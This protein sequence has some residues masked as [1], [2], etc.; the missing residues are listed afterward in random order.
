MIRSLMVGFCLSLMLAFGARA[1][2]P[3]DDPEYYDPALPKAPNEI[4]L[5][6][7]EGER[8]DAEVPDT[9]DLVDN[10]NEAVNFLTRMI[11]PVETDYCIYHLAWPQFNPTIFEIGH[12]SNQ[13]QNAKWAES[14]V[15]MRAMTGNEENLDGDR[16]LICS[17]VR[18]T[19]KDGL[20]Y[21]PVKNRPW[22]YIDPVTQKA[23]KPFADTFAEGR[24]LRALQTWYRHDGNPLWKE[25]IDRKVS[26]LSGLAIKKGDTRYFKLARGYSPWYRETGEGPVVALGDVGQVFSSMTGDGA[27]NMVCW[28][29]QAAAVWYRMTG[30][31]EA[32]DLAGGLARY[33]YR[34]PVFFN[35]ETG[36]FDNY[37]TFFTHCM[38]SLLSYALVAGDE[39]IVE[40]VRR[41]CDQFFD[42]HDPDR[43]GVASLNLHACDY[44]DM[45]QVACMLSRTGHGDY[46]ETIDRWI[47]NGLTHRQT[48]AEEVARRNKMPVTRLGDPATTATLQSLAYWVKGDMPLNRIWPHLHQPDDA[49]ERCRGAFGGAGCCQGN[50]TRAMYLVW[51]SILESRED[52]LRVNLLLNRAA[53][54]ADLSSWLPYEG[55]AKLRIKQ[56]HAEVL[57]RIPAGTEHGQV[58]CRLNGAPV[59]FAWTD[60]EFIRFGPV[61]AGDKILVEFPL[62]ERVIQSAM[63]VGS[64]QRIGT[65]T[66]DYAALSDVSDDFQGRAAGKLNEPGQGN[67]TGAGG[68]LWRYNLGGGAFPAFDG[69]SSLEIPITGNWNQYVD[70]VPMPPF[71][72]GGREATFVAVFRKSIKGDVAMGFV[73]DLAWDTGKNPKGQRLF[74]I[75]ANRIYI[76]SA[77]ESSTADEDTG[78]R[79]IPD[80]TQG[81]MIRKDA[82]GN[83]TYFHQDGGEKDAKNAAWKN[84]TPA[85]SPAGHLK[86]FDIDLGHIG[87]NSLREDEMV[88]VVLTLRGNTLVAI[89]NNVLGYP[90][91]RHRKFRTDAARLKKVRRFVTG[92]RFL[93]W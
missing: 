67:N 3:L 35:R 32:L 64:G 45:L 75:K 31:R 86:G 1:A 78:V 12:G 91:D 11:S 79:L 42:H 50:L 85:T 80:K 30:N 25:I 89:T 84:I 88:Q 53:P 74:K 92:E 63:K 40:W 51:D 26:R 73:R 24:Q 28:M 19:G 44:A 9:L 66:L 6:S 18:Y 23:G 52:Q 54:A 47:R 10:A 87:V 49:N 16:K 90:I 76:G 65:L 60:G 7:F 20:F 82:Q 46:W 15:L 70:T 5:K 62:K 21:V 38:N 41:G 33:L 29:P 77:I 71:V 13:N 93:W 56:P 2:A 68:L 81:L 8:Y 39:E 59:E 58:T 61:K 14:I 17:L 22:A 4:Q 36:R 55:K 83:V 72:L 43:T 34:D 48:T 57:V 27:A 37:G 69:K